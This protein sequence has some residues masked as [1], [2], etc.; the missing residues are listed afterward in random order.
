MTQSSD[1]KVTC[2]DTTW[3]VSESCD[4]DLTEEEKQDLHA[5]IKECQLCQGA[6]SQFEVMFR[7]LREY[8]G[9]GR[10]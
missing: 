2:R 1:R 3:L 5:H 8:F 9:T 6:S 10:R 7:Q 4:R